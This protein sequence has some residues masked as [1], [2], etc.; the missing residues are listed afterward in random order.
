[1]KSPTSDSAKLVDGALSPSELLE[2]L[3]RRG[4]E[5]VRLARASFDHFPGRLRKM[6]DMDL[7]VLGSRAWDCPGAGLPIELV[8][9]ELSD[10]FPP[11]TGQRQ[12]LHDQAIWRWHAPGRE[13]NGCELLIGKDAIPTD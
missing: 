13:N 4:S 7:L 3:S 9:F 5:D 6:N 2:P 8:P 1:M 11:L 10:L 12:E